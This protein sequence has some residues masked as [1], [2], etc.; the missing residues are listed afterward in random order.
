MK[1]SSRAWF[2]VIWLS[3]AL[4][5]PLVVEAQ[6]GPRPNIIPLRDPHFVPSTQASFMKSTDQVLALSLNG[7]AKAYSAPAVAAGPL[8]PLRWP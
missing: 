6:L 8:L 5:A 7:V 3:L 2:H 4:A 1:K